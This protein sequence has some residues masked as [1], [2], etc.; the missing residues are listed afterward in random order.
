MSNSIKKNFAYNML[1]V[2]TRLL[3]PLVTFPYASRILLADGIG[4]VDF[5]NGIIQYVVLLSSLGIPLY[6]VRESARVRSDANELSKTSLEIAILHAGLTILGYLAIIILCITVERIAEN[7]TLF[8]LLSVTVLFNAIGCNWL[9]QGVE[10]FKYITIRSLIVKL[11]SVAGLYLLV[12]TREDLLWYAL[13][14]LLS[15]VGGNV[16]NLFRMRL[17]VKPKS[18]ALN[19]LQPFRHLKPCLKIFALNLIISIYCHLDVIMLGF[20]SGD[21]HVG[22]YVAAHKIE[23]ILQSIVTSL[24]TVMLPRFSNLVAEGKFDE[25]GRL[26]Q[27]SIDFIIALSIPM[28]LGI[29]VCASPVIK[30]FC[31]D[32]YEPSIMTLQLLAPLTLIIGLSNVMGIQILYPQGK[33]HLVMI[34]TGVGA[35]V[36]FCMNLFLIPLYGSG[37]AAI[38]TLIAEVCVTTTMAIIGAKYFP[39]KYFTRQNSLVLL[40]AAMMFAV[41]IFAVRHVDSDVL[42][43]LIIPTIGVVVYA[44]CMFLSKTPI[45]MET[46]GMIKKRFFDRNK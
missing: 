10:D 12:K 5:Y 37:G 20:I 6:A 4:Q 38:S 30:L 17:Y 22:Y 11:I 18:H 15:S 41:C 28:F 8:L 14:M 36:N 23:I 24:G 16:F 45:A 3:F 39:F 21:A 13:M 2:V 19:N 42:K 43:L 46:Y 25:F 9:F 35:V 7:I 34:S 31:G 44:A 26:S 1:N 29:I 27:K 33:E 32:S 40:S